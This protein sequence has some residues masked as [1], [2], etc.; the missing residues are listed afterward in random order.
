MGIAPPRPCARCG[1]I[2]R[3]RC[4]RCAPRAERERG[5]ARARG[6]DDEWAIYSKAWLARFP[7]C[8]M[9]LDG[10]LHADHSRCVQRGERVR[11]QVTD[12]IIAIRAGGSRFDQ[13]NHQS[14]CRGCNAAKDAAR[15]PRV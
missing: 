5:S 13:R 10:Q 6:Y 14:L 9:R 15:G 4:P 7:W 12:H 3:G 8:G 11:A 1:W 2:G